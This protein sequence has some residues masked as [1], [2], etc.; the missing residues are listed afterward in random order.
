[1]RPIDYEVFRKRCVDMTEAG[2]H[3]KDISAALGLTQRLDQP[4]LEEIPRIW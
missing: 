4:N 2:W 1:M 3:Q